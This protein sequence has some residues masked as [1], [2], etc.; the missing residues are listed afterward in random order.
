MLVT[1]QKLLSKQNERV[2]TSAEENDP[3][4]PHGKT[5]GSVDAVGAVSGAGGVEGEGGA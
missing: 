4:Q 2:Q 1:N 5:G 3:G